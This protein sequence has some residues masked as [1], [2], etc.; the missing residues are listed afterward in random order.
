MCPC[1]MTPAEKKRRRVEL[2]WQKANHRSTPLREAVTAVTGVIR[3]AETDEALS[4]Q[5]LTPAHLLAISLSLRQ[6]LVALVDAM[7]DIMEAI[8]G[9]TERILGRT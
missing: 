1:V 8:Q 2:L 5:Y 9:M 6:T 4:G 7:P 3:I